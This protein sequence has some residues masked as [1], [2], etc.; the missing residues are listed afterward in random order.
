MDYLAL[1]HPSIVVGIGG[2]MLMAAMF[3][4]EHYRVKR[5]P[6]YRYIKK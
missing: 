3:A 4:A 5:R 1:V 6:A 2:L